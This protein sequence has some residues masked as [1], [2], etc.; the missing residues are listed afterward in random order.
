MLSLR[1]VFH[2][3]SVKHGIRLWSNSITER[4]SETHHILSQ[5][6]QLP[7]CRGTSMD[8]WGVCNVVL[9]RQEKFLRVY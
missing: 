9:N 4:V 7:L 1:R 6:F 2:H 8:L 5:H 3:V